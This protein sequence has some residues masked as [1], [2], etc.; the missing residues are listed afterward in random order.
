MISLKDRTILRNLAA[1][2]A[3]IAALPIMEK[4]RETW[5]KHNKLERVRPMLL[6]FPNVLWRD[7]LPETVLQCAGEQAREIE[8]LLLGLKTMMQQQR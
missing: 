6:V 1:R 7:L 2:V 5:K 8:W 4:R 3:E